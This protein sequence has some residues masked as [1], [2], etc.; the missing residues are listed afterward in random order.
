MNLNSKRS[1]N[2]N[3]T[4]STEYYENGK[5]RKLHEL[6]AHKAQLSYIQRKFANQ[7]RTNNHYNLYLRLVPYMSS[8][9]ESLAV[10]SSRV[11]SHSAK[12]ESSRES[13]KKVTRVRLESLPVTRVNNSGA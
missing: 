10:K 13:P 9:L 11:S 5:E 2:S 8:S 1:H 7:K 6:D 4:I 3:K 12:F